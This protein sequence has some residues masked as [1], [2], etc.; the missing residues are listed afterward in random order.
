MLFNPQKASEPVV[1]IRH[2]KV[3]NIKIYQFE[4]KKKSECKSQFFNL[5]I[6]IISLI[7]SF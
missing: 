1:I 2:Q 6:L 3:R 7:K 5:K 4:N